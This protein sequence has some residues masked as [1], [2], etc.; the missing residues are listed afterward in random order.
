MPTG[1]PAQ[2]EDVLSIVPGDSGITQSFDSATGTLSLVGTASVETWQS[3]LRTLQ[4][5]NNGTSPTVGNREISIIVSDD[6]IIGSTQESSAAIIDVNVVSNQ[7]SSL[8]KA[9]NS[10][11]RGFN[12]MRNWTG[13]CHGP[14]RNEMTNLARL[15]STYRHENRLDNLRF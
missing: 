5:Q 14:Q 11:P 13:R 15:W 3:V 10:P 2:S 12:C 9:C 4:Y 8:K 7:L 6:T 1:S